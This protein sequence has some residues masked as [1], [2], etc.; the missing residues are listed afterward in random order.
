MK[1]L[2]TMLVMLLVDLVIFGLIIPF[3]V[4][5]IYGVYKARSCRETVDVNPVSALLGGAR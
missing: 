2:I 5:K 4:K 1:V 3:V